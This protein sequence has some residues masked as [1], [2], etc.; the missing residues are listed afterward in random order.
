MKRGPE[1]VIGRYALHGEI[2]S[3][4]MATVHLGRLLG[5]VGF[6]RTVAV[7]RLHAH[8][9][10][11]PEFVSMFLDE[12][13][14]AGRIQHPNVVSTLDVVA[15]EGELFLVMEYVHGESLSILLRRQRKSGEPMPPAIVAS[16]LCGALH[17]LHAAHE[18]RDERGQPLGIVHRDVSP[19]NI[20]VGLDGVA[21]VLDFGVAM[22]VGRLQTTREGQVKG[23]LAYMAPEQLH[24]GKVDR[25]VDVYAAAV[26][27]W[28]AFAGR[29]LFHGDN[30]GMVITQVLSGATEP[31][32]HY[33]SKLVESVDAIVMRGLALDP[34]ARWASARELAVALEDALGVASPRRVGEWIEAVASK[35]LAERARLVEDIESTSSGPLD[36][37]ELASVRGLHAAEAADSPGDPEAEAPTTISDTG[38]RRPAAATVELA[39]SSLP[40]DSSS[41]L[42]SISVVKP[43]LAGSLASPSAKLAVA[44]GV[45]ALVG[46]VAL[47]VG[48]GAGESSPAAP[49]TDVDSTGHHDGS[50]TPLTTAEPSAPK[51]A[52][53]S[54]EPTQSATAQAVPSAAS[55]A[56]AGRAKPAPV[57]KPRRPSAKPTSRPPIRFTK[58]D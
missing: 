44:L 21:R 56:D 18:A 29:A 39:P 13:R 24:G 30:E 33:G 58:P 37:A 48:L 14:L 23:K 42:S 10:K 55:A 45:F 35:P 9:A 3:G 17:G 41:D 36:A 54:P 12:A 38:H 51:P 8:F 40:S 11:D 6:S 4:G 15:T 49:A 19:Q 43:R 31:P 47:L 50:E 5:Q 22:A 2:A 27:L 26:V 7:K 52:G 16:I 57:A 1:R 20:M 34:E 25:R 32:S 28:E 53:T 46:L